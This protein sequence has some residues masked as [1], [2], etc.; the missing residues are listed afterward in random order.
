[1]ALNFFRQRDIERMDVNEIPEEFINYFETLD[2]SGK[3]ALI[4][5]RPDLAKALGFVL[6]EKEDH[7]V[8][9][10]DETGV[11]NDIPLDSSSAQYADGEAEEPSE[12]EE[13]SDGAFEDEL[14]QIR[15][16][17]YEGKDLN[18][19]LT[20][21]MPE[22][23]ALAIPKEAK[24]CM[25]HRIPLEE[26]QIKYRY[27]E[28]LPTY[29]I[30]LRVCP[31][32]HRVYLE[33][34]S[35][36]AVHEALVQRGIPHT[37]Y[38]LDLTTQ[39]LRSQMPAYE[40]TA[41]D[42]LYIP[43]IW[44]EEEPKCPI[45]DEPVYEVP[46]LK[47]YKDRVVRFTGYRCDRCGKYLVRRA[48]AMDLIDRCAE[49]GIPSIEMEKL[50]KKVPQK[51]QISPK[52]VKSDYMIE[53]GRRS[54][55]QYNVTGN[56]YQLSETDTVVVSDS[57]YCT[58]D[59]HDD[60]E[61]VVA[62]IRVQEKRG[63]RKGY[64]FRLGYC[65]DCQKYYMAQED[66][67]ALYS[68]GR[69]E[70][71]ILR[72][73]DDSDYQI[74]SGE[75]FNLERDHLGS[76]E[77][78]IS[79]EQKTIMNSSDYVSPFATGDYDDGNLSF[80]KYRSRIKYGKRLEEL[81]GYEPKPYSYR[82]DISLDGETETY[83][84]GAADIFLEGKQQVISA[85]SDFGHDLIN[86]QTIKVK[87]GGK[88][89]NIK[90]SRQFDIDNA[91]LYG[92]ANLRTDEDI[93]FKSGITDPFL[94]RVLNMRKRQHNL[95]DIFV[96]I[97]ENQN[98]IVNTS[99]KKN[100]IV[101]GCAGSGKTMV[102]LHRL[103]SLNYKEK[104]FDFSRDALILTPNDQFT[105][106][107]KGLAEELQIGNIQRAS[108]EQYYI[109][110]LML[111][112]PEF[113]LDGRVSSEMIVRQIFVDYIY[114]DQFRTDFSAA[115]ASVIEKRNG[116]A[117]TLTN[118]LK[119][120]DQPER[121]IDLSDDSRV[122]QHIRYT[123][124]S[125]RSIVDRQESEIASAIEEHKRY[126]N[127]KKY[128]Q[129]RVQSLSTTS[130]GIIA[131]SLP[132]VYTK[133]GSFLSE[134]QYTIA[135][136]NEQIESLNAEREAV[137]RRLLPFG[138]S[139]RLEELDKQ[140]KSAKRKLNNENKRQEEELPV[141]S[142]STEGLDE[143]AII[144]WMRQVMLI[145]PEVR[146]EV[147]LCSNL[148]EEYQHLTEELAGV[149][150][151][152]QEAELRVEEK[153]ASRYSDDVKKAIA[154]LYSEMDKYSLLNT[155]QLIFDQAV[156]Q[157]KEANSITNIQGKYHRYDL[158]ARLLFAM[159]YYGKAIGTTRFM[160]IDEGQDIAL[161]EYRLIYELNQHRVVF[162]IFGDTNQLMKRGRGITDWSEIKK[163]FGAEVYE[164]N[165]NYRNTNQITRFCNSSFD[166]KVTQTGVDGANVREIPRK[167]LEKEIAALNITTE[168]IAILVPRGVQKNRYLK[169]DMLPTSISRLIGD[170][171]DNGFI[172][173][174]YVDEVK[175]IEFDK[176]YVVGNK[177]SR[178]EKYIAYTRA[179]SELILV[180]DD[181]IDDYN[182]GSKE[183][184]RVKKSS[185]SN[186]KTS[187]GILT[188]DAPKPKQ[189][190]KSKDTLNGDDSEDHTKNIS[191]V[192]IQFSTEKPVQ[193]V[194]AD[195]T[196]IVNVDAIVTSCSAEMD[197]SGV[198]DF[199]VHQAA[200]PKLF[201]DTKR[202]PKCEVGDVRITNGYNLP[203]KY[204]IHAH[205]PRWRE[206]DG[207]GSITLLEQTYQR[208]LTCAAENS[209]RSIAIPT[210]STGNRGF[211][212]GVAAQTAI[213]AVENYFENS[214]GMI[215][216]VV[217]VVT[218]DNEVKT[219][220][221]L[222]RYY[223]RDREEIIVTGQCKNCVRQ[224]FEDRG[225]RIEDQRPKG[226]LY[227]FGNRR[228]L[229]Q[230][231]LEAQKLFNISGMFSVKDGKSCWVTKTKK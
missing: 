104:K 138:K 162:N 155:Y 89:Y 190:A 182:D 82:V 52:L 205:G 170:N 139:E 4:G 164:L 200:G 131:E 106:H 181:Q 38:D 85:N 215:E 42:I 192:S 160:C 183:I 197:G 98:R 126:V 12:D 67:K 199:A 148:R 187:K 127:R 87:K 210:L 153:K 133:I 5:S 91:H 40:F 88:E 152:I 44:V 124:D 202:L 24:K 203:C 158:Y 120:I 14:E 168:R 156:S 184:K 68:I 107:I 229:L 118:L 54:E 219:Y 22:L 142:A 79:D 62:L 204:I 221:E 46:C 9:V 123:V 135:G 101:Q 32:C 112:S 180:V 201:E 51:K 29:G 109:D 134:R 65:A 110:T 163:I 212:L 61:E 48:A 16:N 188:F 31:A 60:T 220:E 176:A 222:L 17:F 23:E 71:I 130:S 185:K 121:A 83:Y 193:V 225:F 41:E 100:I 35:M 99:F 178:N 72:D 97:Q 95:T 174:M 21:D 224:F 43:D 150:A 186:K 108:V 90:L 166:M 96:T 119:E 137:Q 151:L 114:S 3:A 74:T 172:A 58:I 231:V 39:Y 19:V 175:G 1:M 26:K 56:C 53:N 50:V 165:E 147:R 129:E 227:V 116:L 76:V 102:L 73:I 70:V 149:D 92:Y 69:P 217:F 37:F 57:I 226:S 207:K 161:N 213:H 45:H 228:N 177:M 6:P 136:L 78:K 75:V 173:L 223:G 11:T 63:G 167:E 230:P 194:K 154:Y 196:K 146:E 18:V 8:S 33:E 81:S 20:D 55:F 214:P 80:A 77:K 27:Q 169:Q 209:I 141:L 157:F 84:I 10:E 66:Y 179:L 30:V 128:L 171:M 218:S 216:H 13:T 132:R 144:A 25:L 93:I 115:Y 47:K 122:I 36:Y 113:R 125:V 15:H 64:L 94:V 49:L 140:I 117:K 145:V 111:Y 7:E 34:T 28:N 159:R 59:G 195:I 103:S 86:Y 208:I 211:D 206:D 143:E 2:D 105:L 189:G 191:R 198:L